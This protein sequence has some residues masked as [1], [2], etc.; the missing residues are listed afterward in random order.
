MKKWVMFIL[1]VLSNEICLSNPKNSKW[2]YAYSDEGFSACYKKNP[3]LIGFNF[4][5]VN[6]KIITSNS[7]KTFSKYFYNLGAH[8]EYFLGD[9]DRALLSLRFGLN[10]TN[11]GYEFQKDNLKQNYVLSYLSS[12]SNYKILLF[13]SQFYTTGGLNL[14]YLYDVESAIET[15]NANIEKIVVIKDFSGSEISNNYNRF[16]L[17]G[18]VGVGYDL[19]MEGYYISIEPKYNFSFFNH[20]NENNQEL[21]GM[22]FKN[23]FWSLNFGVTFAL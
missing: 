22:N 19:N 7:I 6:S 11:L 12:N 17:V 23:E 20:I 1:Y 8:Y 5:I 18:S 21:K 4:G 14:N 10:F 2:E 9:S 16:D 3:T 15:I 13:G